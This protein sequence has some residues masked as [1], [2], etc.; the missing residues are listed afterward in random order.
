ME[1]NAMI[2]IKGTQKSEFEKPQVMEFITGGKLQ[3]Y[4]SKLRIS[5]EE[6]ELIG[7]EG[8]TTTFVV[9]GGQ[10]TMERSGRLTAKMEFVEGKRTE[11]LYSL[12]MGAMLLGVTARKVE[13][14]MTEDGGSIHLEYGVELERTFLGLNTYDIQVKTVEEGKEQYD[15]Q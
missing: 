4:G 15:A 1:K 9:D 12:D 2:T 7:M 13:T 11:S 6:S 8:V 3:R 14:D 5:Y 10:V